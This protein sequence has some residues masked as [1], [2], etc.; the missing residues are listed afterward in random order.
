MLLGTGEG[1][2]KKSAEQEAARQALEKFDPALL[3]FQ[4]AEDDF[5]SSGI[6]P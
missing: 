5:A 6:E 2:N 1:K 4:E 3:D